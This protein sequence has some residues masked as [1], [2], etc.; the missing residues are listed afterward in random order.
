MLLEDGNENG[1]LVP[2]LAQSDR[3]EWRVFARYRAG[4]FDAVTGLPHGW[5]ASPRLRH[6]AVS[7]FGPGRVQRSVDR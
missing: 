2:I 1:D 5:K 7:Y 4:A 6:L 3:I